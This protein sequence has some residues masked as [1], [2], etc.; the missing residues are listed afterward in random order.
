MT[1]AAISMEGVAKVYE[2]RRVVDGVDLEVARGEVLAIMGPSGGGKTTLLRMM[3]GLTSPDE[4]RVHV[5][6]VTLRYE[7]DRDLQ[8]RRDMAY[9][10]QKPVSF[11]S[12]VRDNVAYALRVRGVQESGERVERSL[13]MVGLSDLAGQMATKLSGGEMQRM[14]FARAT[15]FEP[16]IL[17]L[18]EFTANLDPRNVAMLEQAALRFHEEGGATLVVVTH[19]LFQARRISDRAALMMDGALVE[20]GP[21]EEVFERPR[22]ERTRAFVSGEMVF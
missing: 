11:A 20:V 16:S 5:G 19:N 6:G 22:D 7:D 21:T 17:L 4:G 9:I 1:G 15:V 3:N 10:L 14:A 13:E 12:S 18:D 2:G 8:V